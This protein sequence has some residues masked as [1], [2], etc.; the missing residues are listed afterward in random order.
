[1][2]RSGAERSHELS[3]LG[4]K[5]RAYGRRLGL[6]TRALSVGYREREKGL[7]KRKLAVVEQS[8]E[9]LGQCVSV[10]LQEVGRLVGHLESTQTRGAGRE[11]IRHAREAVEPLAHLASVM[12]DNERSSGLLGAE[13]LLVRF[14]A[15]VDLL[16]EGRVCSFRETAFFI[17]QRDDTGRSGRYT[18]RVTQ[19]QCWRLTGS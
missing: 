2:R 11:Y 4:L 3:Q 8:H 19:R 1:M 17:K 16:Q 18:G 14:V 6:A 15:V 7:D 12:L 9:I 13:K 5:V 10:L